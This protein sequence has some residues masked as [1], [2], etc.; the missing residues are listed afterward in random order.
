MDQYGV[1]NQKLKGG[2]YFE[3]LASLSGLVDIN[4]QDVSF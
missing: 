1:L 2:D 4:F 3:Y